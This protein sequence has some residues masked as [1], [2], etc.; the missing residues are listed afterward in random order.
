ML[1]EYRLGEQLGKGAFGK[2]R[3]HWWLCPYA[4]VGGNQPRSTLQMH[5][6]QLPTVVESSFGLPISVDGTYS[7]MPTLPSLERQCE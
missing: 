1:E 6:F 4:I 2:E 7:T 3:W 5:P